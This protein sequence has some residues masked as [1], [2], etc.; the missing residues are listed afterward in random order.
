MG[1]LE[2]K[3]ALITGGASGMGMVASKL[4]AAEGARVVLTDVADE[5]GQIEVARIDAP[6]LEV[7]PVHLD[8]RIVLTE[9]IGDVPRGR[10]VFVLQDQRPRSARPRPRLGHPLTSC[11]LAESS[12]SSVST[13]RATARTASANRAT[14]SPSSS[15]V[16][17]NGGAKRV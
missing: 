15:S 3:V 7:D 10:R 11:G 5:A 1:R 14:I 12:A 4:F 2:G 16:V 9:P 8:L 17:V 13:S 6:L